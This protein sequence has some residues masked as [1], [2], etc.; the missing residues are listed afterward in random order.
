[1]LDKK[2]SIRKE[3][4]IRKSSGPR[5]T[6]IFNCPTCTNTFRARSDALKTHSSKCG[7]CAH[8]KLPFESIY[9]SIKNDHRKIKVDLTYEEYIEFTKISECHYCLEVIP[10]SP[11]GTINGKFTSRAYFLDRKD[12]N[13]G[14]SKSN[15]VVCCTKCNKSRS[16]NYSYEE[17]YGMTE[18]LRK[19][20]K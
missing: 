5:Y 16:N 9:N 2:L 8:Q 12:N 18:F 17:W 14:Y 11:Y 4:E 7:S 1:M 20:V 19:L 13:S 6:Y 3:T 10:W 15:C